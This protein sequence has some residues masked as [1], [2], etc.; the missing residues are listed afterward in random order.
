MPLKIGGGIGSRVPVGPLMNQYP[1]SSQI[2]LKYS[3]NHPG[4]VR[5]L[6]SNSILK[7]AESHVLY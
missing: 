7:P 6:Q 2:Q 1:H 5:K 4:Q 3:A